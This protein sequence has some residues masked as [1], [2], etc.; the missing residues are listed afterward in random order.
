M[1]KVQSS[2]VPV[3][4]GE[5]E[6]N[7]WSSFWEFGPL[8]VNPS[9]CPSGQH[10]G[11]TLEGG[12]R[13]I[14]QRPSC[15]VVHFPSQGRARWVGGRRWRLSRRRQ[16][17]KGVSFYFPCVSFLWNKLY[18]FF[19]VYR[20]LVF[21]ILLGMLVAGSGSPHH[22]TMMH[23]RWAPL[24]GHF[25]VKSWLKHCETMVSPF[26]GRFCLVSKRIYFLF[27]VGGYFMDVSY[28]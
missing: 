17:S 23:I 15:S 21:P 1:R 7:K 16:S 24:S 22:A 27:W 4:L 14:G 13:H 5:K 11:L 2:Q 20:F 3:W 12:H 10:L 18:F 6:E 26:L 9:V 28:R 25:G 19:Q 8:F